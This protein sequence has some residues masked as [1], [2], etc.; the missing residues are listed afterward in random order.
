MCRASN[1]TE[2]K[3]KANKIPLMKKNSVGRSFNLTAEGR[4]PAWVRP[5]AREKVRPSAGLPSGVD[6]LAVQQSM[7]EEK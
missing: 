5:L 6:R 4:E 7:E 1:K 3:K 2:K